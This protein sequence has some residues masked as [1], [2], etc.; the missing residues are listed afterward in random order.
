[1]NVVVLGLAI[2]LIININTALKPSNNNML[3][4]GV[5]SGFIAG[6]AGTGGAIRGLTLASFNLNKDVFIATSALIDL[7]IDASRA[8]VYTA[9][10]YFNAKYFYLIPY[11]VTVSFLGSYLAK[12][13]LNHKSEK[14]FR[15]I[16]L[17]VIFTTAAFQVVQY[18]HS[19]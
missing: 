14:V 19:D 7:G 6:I 9:S 3:I 12:I 8:I 16:V 4:G 10:G 15:Y 17:F 1:M 2:F 13:I 18:L 11:L 5:T